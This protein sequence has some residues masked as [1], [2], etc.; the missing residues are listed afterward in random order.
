MDFKNIFLQYLIP[1]IHSVETDPFADLDQPQT[2]NFTE[3]LEL[4]MKASSL[5]K[6]EIETEDSELSIDNY[7]PLNTEIKI[8]NDEV[9][10]DNLPYVDQPEIPME[11]CELSMNTNHFVKT[12]NETEKDKVCQSSKNSVKRADTYQS[13]DHAKKY[14][15]DICFKRFTQKS[16]LNTHVLTLHDETHLACG[17][18]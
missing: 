9:L 6:T 11:D 18:P 17:L 10:N 13:K 16:G 1:Y 12:E 5:V 3:D 7:Y 15:C 4:S 8:E 2:D 14:K